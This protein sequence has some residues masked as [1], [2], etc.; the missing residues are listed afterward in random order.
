MVVR[1][2]Y[3]SVLNTVS[4][5]AMKKLRARRAWCERRMERYMTSMVLSLVGQTRPTEDARSACLQKN[6][7]AVS[8]RP[9]YSQEAEYPKD[10][11]PE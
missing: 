10:G 4:N 11:E 7:A 1:V 5:I 3:R 8:E 6:S 9:K 2:T